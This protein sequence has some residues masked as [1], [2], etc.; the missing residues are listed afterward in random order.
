MISHDKHRRAQS[1]R[2]LPISLMCARK[3][4]GHAHQRKGG[5]QLAVDLNGPLSGR[6]GFD[7]RHIHRQIRR[8]KTGIVLEAV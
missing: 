3:R 1:A 6:K 8:V 4:K 7:K 2:D 5:K